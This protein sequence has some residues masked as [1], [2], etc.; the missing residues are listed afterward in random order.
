M[1]TGYRK[2]NYITIHNLTQIKKAYLILT[3]HTLHVYTH[4]DTFSH[5]ESS[6]FIKL[7]KNFSEYTSIKVLTFVH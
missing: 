2:M 7:L 3:E 1:E 4:T 6:L 5:L